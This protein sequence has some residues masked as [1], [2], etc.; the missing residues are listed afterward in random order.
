[1]L[2]Y[3]CGSFAITLFNL[4]L[5]F[6][7][8]F[9]RKLSGLA[10]AYF[11][12][13]FFIA[14]WAL[15]YGIT[16]GGFFDYNTTLTWN[17]F[18]QSMAMM[19]APFFFK[20]CCM[21][22]D[23]Y[24]KKRGIFLFYVELA[25]I[26]AFGIAFTP[27]YVSGFWSF[28]VY[29]YQPLGG[30]LYV[31]Y[32]ALFHWCTAHGFILVLSK[33]REFSE[34]QKKQLKLFLIATGTSYFG[35]STLFLAPLGIPFPSY[36]IF[37]ILAYVL[38]TGFAIHKYQFLDLPSLIQTKEVV[39]LHD[40]KLMLLGLL[41]SSINH[42]IKNPLFM[43]QEFSRKLMGVEAVSKS[44]EASD[45]VGKM[46]SQVGRMSRLVERL[47]DF[48]RPNVKRDNDVEEINLRQVVDN[49]LFFASP[50]LKYQNVEVKIDIPENF[51]ELKG[52]KSQFEVIFLNLIINAYHAMPN[53]GTLNIQAKKTDNSVEVAVSD[54]GVGIPKD[55]LKNIFKPFYTTKQKSG[56]GLGLYIVKTLVEQNKG[57]I[58]VSSKNKQGTQFSIR[59]FQ[60]ERF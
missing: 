29:K 16:L 10:R 26:N 22:V 49:A 17:K 51:P 35:G 39:A 57:T 33:Y 47:G 54:T 11:W 40:E 19:I 32:V 31:I 27:Y 13:S 38:A 58:I 7:T 60:L 34:L 44:T 18:C 24:E 3:A 20:Y 36:G 37:L 59:F 6:L 4:T 53:G 21:L 43:L 42:E 55:Q 5:W 45:L 23:E 52:D 28:G 8:F 46:S 56:T 50:E 30:P 41:S 15:G 2:I 25:A 9:G 1:M 48:A 14:V 12:W